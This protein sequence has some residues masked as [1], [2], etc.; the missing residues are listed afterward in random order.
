MTNMLLAF[1]ALLYRLQSP[2]PSGIAAH[3]LY[4]FARINIIPEKGDKFIFMK[5]TIYGT[6]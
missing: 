2:S 6:Y 5:E 1:C 4:Y 3:L